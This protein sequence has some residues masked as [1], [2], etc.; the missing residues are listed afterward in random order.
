VPPLQ[1]A[2][3]FNL[4]FAAVFALFTSLTL[5]LLARLLC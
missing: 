1:L 3:S 4:I 5:T 2:F